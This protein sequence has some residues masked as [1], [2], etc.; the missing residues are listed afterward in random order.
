MSAKSFNLQA[1]FFYCSAW[2]YRT[3]D[4]TIQNGTNQFSASMLPGAKIMREL[5]RILTPSDTEAMRVEGLYRTF[6]EYSRR[7]N[8][9]WSPATACTT[10]KLLDSKTTA[11][12]CAAF[13]AGFM[14]LALTPAPFGLGAD[15]RNFQ[16]VTYTGEK[17]SG[18]GAGFVSFHAT[19][20]CLGLAPNVYTKGG[21]KL[22]EVLFG[23]IFYLWANHKVV[24]YIDKYFDPT[25]GCQYVQ[26]EDMAALKI[27]GWRILG[28]DAPAMT[29][30]DFDSAA[31]SDKA[32][33]SIL[34]ARTKANRTYYFR[35][36]PETLRA[37]RGMQWEGPFSEA[38]IEWL[39]EELKTSP[40]SPIHADRIFEAA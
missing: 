15:R 34:A 36:T 30:D 19:P 13:A 31:M 5:Q 32:G 1:P 21:T 9:M 33:A 20:D 25:Y 3:S 11:A 17:V 28:K 35:I 39:A 6:V 24:K 14:S 40:S 12:E 8:W 22:D 38:Q 26:E 18:K 2:D 16:M 27:T 4:C 23:R 29:S 37:G 7:E 10:P